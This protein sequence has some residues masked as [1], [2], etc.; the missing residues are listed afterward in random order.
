MAMQLERPLT[1]AATLAQHAAPR[2]SS[3]AA[4]VW[5]NFRR[6]PGALWG[7]GILATLVLLALLAPGTA[8]Y[9]PT[10]PAIMA[11]PQPPSRVHLFGTDQFGRDTFSRVLY[12]G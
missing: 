11:R 1:S 2:A 4:I 3:Q 7:M 5:R 10:K 12:G 8:P 6:N 9:D